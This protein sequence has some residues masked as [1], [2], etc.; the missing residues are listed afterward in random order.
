KVGNSRWTAQDI[1]VHRISSRADLNNRWADY[2]RP[3]G[4]N[5]AD[6]LEVGNGKA[7]FLI[8]SDVRSMTP[9][10]IEILGNAVNQA[11]YAKLSP[12]R[13][14][15]QPEADFASSGAGIL[16]ETNEGFMF[17]Y[18]FSTLTWKLK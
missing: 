16:P 9:G 15:F 17:L 12:I 2:A 8:G 1:K 5:D 4:W 6:M 3:G 14:F 7:P 13:L 11:E 10:T 18:F